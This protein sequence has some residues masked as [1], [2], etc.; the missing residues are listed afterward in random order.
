MG[1]PLSPLLAEIFL[2]SFENN[3]FSSGNP[4]LE[5]CLFW[6][7]YEIFPTAWRECSPRT[8]VSV[9]HPP[10]TLRRSTP[11]D[12]REPDSLSGVYKL[13]CKDCPC[14]YI[15]QS[16]RSITIR[17]SEHKRCLRTGSPGSAFADHLIAES[18]SSDF[19]PLLL[20]KEEKG[21]RLDA[22][23]VIEISKTTPLILE[24]SS[25]TAP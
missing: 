20:H 22:L 1:S 15:G 13:N 19:K 14:H 6:R 21:R 25:S 3:L 8:S 17:V 5:H 10:G 12:R 24:Q 4:L 23:E 9:L 16:G 2:D 7:R 18:H 11:Q